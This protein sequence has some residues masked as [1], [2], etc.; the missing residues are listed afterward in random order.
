MAAFRSA[1]FSAISAFSSGDSHTTSTSPGL[2][3][4][5]SLA[6]T[7]TTLP[8]HLARTNSRPV[9]SPTPTAA[10]Q[11]RQPPVRG[12]ACHVSK[13]AR[14]P[15]LPARN[16]ARTPPALTSDDPAQPARRPPARRSLLLAAAT[17]ANARLDQ[18]ALGKL[19]P[20]EVSATA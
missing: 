18:T 4:S 10:A 12:A 9:G 8:D 6:R 20:E 15:G 14:A 13:P 7:S 3:Q 19:R 1:S 11:R 16:A 5:P 2:T 17:D